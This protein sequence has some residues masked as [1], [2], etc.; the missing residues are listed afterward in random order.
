MLRRVRGMVH[1]SAGVGRSGTMVAL[2]MCLMTIANTRPIDIHGIVS[3][4]RR[5]RA[6]AVQ[7][8]EQYLSLYKLVLQ[9][10]EQ[11]GCLSA[12]EVGSFYRVLQAARY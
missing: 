8:L 2:E 9:F 4:L 7:S 11:N 6:L 5:C 3:N 12:E 10:G 1:C